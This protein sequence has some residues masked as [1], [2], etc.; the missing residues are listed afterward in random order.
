MFG[1]L[2]PADTQWLCSGGFVTETQV[3][4]N[5]LEDGTWIMCQIIHSSIGYV[6]FRYVSNTG[7]VLMSAPLR[8]LGY[9]SLLS[10]S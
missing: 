3:W 7:N 6:C 1:D 4:Y 8:R 10:S 2:V 5:V 9:G